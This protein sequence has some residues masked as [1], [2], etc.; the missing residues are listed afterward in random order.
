MGLPSIAGAIAGVIAMGSWS[1]IKSAAVNFQIGGSATMPLPDLQRFTAGLPLRTRPYAALLLE[2]GQ[3]FGVDPYLL[4]GIM[5]RESSSGEALT[6][7]GPTGTG[8]WTARRRGWQISKGGIEVQSLPPGWR[9]FAPDP[10]YYSGPPFVVPPDF[11]GWGRG[12]MQVDYYRF[13]TWVRSN[14]WWEPRIIIRKS[15]E[16]L[17]GT[18]ETMALV[19]LTGRPLVVA[20]VAA[21]NLEP[22]AVIASIKAGR[23]PDEHTTGAD[24][25][26]GRLGVV[27]RAEQFRAASNNMAPRIA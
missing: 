16:I 9:E 14:A 23:S 10:R 8:D 3:D 4:A 27:P 20:A 1:R 19:G 21:Y 7:R 18:F 22:A 5:E 17:K 6:P 26:D 24:Y 25:A 12:L 11:I 2:A 13:N 15:A